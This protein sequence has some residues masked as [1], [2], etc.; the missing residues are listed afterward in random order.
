MADS[1]G[2]RLVESHTPHWESGVSWSVSAEP[3]LV[4]GPGTAD[5]AHLLWKVVG[6]TRLSDG[7]LAVLAGGPRS[8]LLFE[9][10]GTLLKT[11]GGPGD[12]PGEF[13][14]PQHLQ[15]RSGDTLVV[16]E[17]RYGR[18]TSF[19]ATG[20]LLGSAR[21]GPG[22]VRE[23]LGA[24]VTSESLTPLVGDTFVAHVHT[25]RR[26]L[27][28]PPPFTRHRPALG[29]AV[30]TP[31][32]SATVLGEL[33]R[34]GGVEVAFTESG[35]PILREFPARSLVAAGTSPPRVFITDGATFRVDVYGPDGSLDAVFRK[36][37]EP[38]PISDEA[39]AAAR[40]RMM[41]WSGV[42]APRA[43]ADF[44]ARMDRVEMQ[45]Y[46]PAITSL[47]VDRLGFIWARHET[48]GWNVLSPEGRWLGTLHVP[49]HRLYDVGEDYILGWTFDDDTRERIEEYALHRA[50]SNP[51]P[52]RFSS[53]HPPPIR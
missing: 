16:W 7:R 43:R 9:R 6:A 37:G 48:E 12:G 13:R 40:G 17:G 8:L 26:N 49:L 15:R 20:R 44:E 35:F 32:P 25:R 39:R 22:L 51:V 2:I 50:A 45:R 28:R 46:Y 38:V 1:S 27:A 41:D 14:A 30:V 52:Q 3:S 31:G 11:V 34:Y 4:I 29:Y 23:A 21:L 33:G 10:D 53:P 47:F 36:E 24:G 19:D 5:A 42:A 18:R